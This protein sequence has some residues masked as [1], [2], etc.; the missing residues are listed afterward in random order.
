MSILVIF[1][2]IFVGNKSNFL[3]NKSD[4]VFNYYSVAEPSVMNSLSLDPSLEKS[5]NRE[6]I[7]IEYKLK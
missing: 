6:I 7:P 1:K 4:I 5:L 2:Q 3:R